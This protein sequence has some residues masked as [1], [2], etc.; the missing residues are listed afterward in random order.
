[1]EEFLGGDLGDTNSVNEDRS[2]EDFDE[3]LRAV[4]EPPSLGSGWH[5]LVDHGQAG[6]ARAAALGSFGS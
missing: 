1:M 3:H 6:H 4:E 2:S 5:Q